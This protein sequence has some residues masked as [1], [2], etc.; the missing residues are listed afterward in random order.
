MIDR[1]SLI[2]FFA[3]GAKYLSI[4]AVPIIFVIEDVA[5][6]SLLLGAERFIS[7]ICSLEVHSYFNRRLIHRNYSIEYVNNQHLPIISIGVMI[8]FVFGIFYSIQMSIVYL[9]AYLMIISI[10][11]AIFN[12]MIRRAQALGKIDIFSILS[13]LKSI[14]LVIAMLFAFIYNNN[15]FLFF[16]QTFAFTSLTICLSLIHI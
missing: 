6:F 10:C 9:F 7:F 14:C 8:S 4:L 11:G 16:V 15:N 2:R 1:Y 12:E 3:V 13:A 5:L